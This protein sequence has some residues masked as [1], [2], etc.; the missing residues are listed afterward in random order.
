MPFTN[1]WPPPS[2]YHTYACSPEYSALIWSK[3]FFYPT[4]SFF[5]F[6]ITYAI[7]INIMNYMSDDLPRSTTG[8]KTAGSFRQKKKT[9]E[10]KQRSISRL[11]SLGE[12]A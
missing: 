6:I 3:F 12:G 4:T 5:F 8:R 9:A 1:K 7:A 11:L 2:L 10:W